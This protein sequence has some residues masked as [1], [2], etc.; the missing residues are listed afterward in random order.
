[1][2][3]T[4][5]GVTAGA[6]VYQMWFYPGYHTF[7]TDRLGLH[8]GE[9]IPELLCFLKKTASHIPK[10]VNLPQLA[11]QVTG[12]PALRGPKLRLS[13]SPLSPTQTSAGGRDTHGRIHLLKVQSLHLDGPP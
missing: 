12:P 11:P 5:L 10:N 7:S 9:G 3:S 13:A 2:I 6:P 1:M 8:P 4:L